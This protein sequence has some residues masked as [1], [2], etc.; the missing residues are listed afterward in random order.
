MLYLNPP[1]YLI[2]GLTLFPDHQ[3]PAAPGPGDAV[4]FYYLPLRPRLAWAQGPDGARTPDFQFLKY[5]DDSPDAPRGGA[6]LNFGVDLGVDA[7]VLDRV[8]RELAGKLGADEQKV[9]L[10][11]VP[12]ADG[13]VSLMLFGARSGESGASGG[14]F[15]TRIDQAAKPAL[16]GDNAAVFS[17][18]LAKDGAMLAEESLAGK[19]S[20]LGVIYSLQFNALKPAYRVKVTADWE[21]VARAFAQQTR[22]RLFF[23]S[24]DIRNTTQELVDK[25]V[26]RIEAD[27][28]VTAEESKQAVDQKAAFLAQLTDMITTR[29]FE[30]K[31]NPA[32]PRDDAGKGIGDT[33]RSVMDVFSANPGVSFGYSQSKAEASMK[34][35]LSAEATERITVRMT[36]APQ[37]YLDGLMDTVT[38]AGLDPGRFVKAVVLKDDFFRRRRVNVISRADFAGNGIAS[39]VVRLAYGGEE[40]TVMLTGSDARATVSWPA[41]L[42]NRR[43]RREVKVSYTVSFV[44]DEL[45]GQRPAELTSREVAFTGDDFEVFPYRDLFVVRTLP[46]EAAAGFPWERYPRVEVGVRYR[47]DAS[48]VAI[49]RT[50]R[51]TRESPRA[52]VRLFVMDFRKTGYEVRIRYSGGQ[53]PPT[54][55]V[56]RP[57]TPAEAD[58]VEVRDPFPVR[59]VVNFYADDVDWEQVRRVLVDARYDDAAGGVRERRAL[60][61]NA[62]NPSAQF[63]AYG[64]DPERRDVG[65]DLRVIRKGGEVETIAGSL[66]ADGEVSLGQGARMTG[67]RYVQVSLEPGASRYPRITVELRHRDAVEG[68]SSSRTLEFTRTQTAEPRAWSFPFSSQS[69]GVYEYKLRYYNASSQVAAQFPA[70]AADFA[71]ASDPVLVVPLAPKR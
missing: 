62:A 70:R 24:A 46:V 10:S 65:Y 52:S 43:M 51:L 53:A 49:E 26:I 68:V 28:F 56:E 69:E 11:P 5:V 71:T 35:N 29:F 17:V 44:H 34:V 61:L 55:D 39:I 25:R 4:Q 9:S 57:W 45:A 22:A 31:V 16:F 21:Q 59:R 15:V 40:Q 41:L 3:N 67:R 48:A 32:T 2:E 37:A 47:D 64:T 23:A 60:E 63:V 13:S 54:S 12:L 19:R 42:D 50:V 33:L 18:S 36:A 30:P 6:F 8:R 7:G 27:T 58:A 1:Y 38:A 20:P 14:T 66:T